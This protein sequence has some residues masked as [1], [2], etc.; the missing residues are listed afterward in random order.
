MTRHQILCGL[1]R[2]ARPGKSSA[3][4]ALSQWLQAETNAR[5]IAVREL[6]AGGFDG[7]LHYLQSGAL[8][9]RFLILEIPDRHDTDTRRRRKRI[10]CPV[11]KSAS[12]PALR[13]CHGRI[14]AELSENASIF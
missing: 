8:G 1:R 6:D 4:Q 7:A 12:S 9:R 10:L 5:R 2:D 3:G 14:I 13:W 11:Q